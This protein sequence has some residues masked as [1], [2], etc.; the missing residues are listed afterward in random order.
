MSLLLATVAERRVA[1]TPELG[2]LQE[3]MPTSLKGEREP[4]R[5]LRAPPREMRASLIDGESPRNW[6]ELKRDCSTRDA[7]ASTGMTDTLGVA[8][9]GYVEEVRETATE[10][11]E[12]GVETP[13]VDDAV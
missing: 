4:R 12:E 13:C 8:T 11:A 1:P 9:V 6:I 2:A 3:S 10:A 7:T 5:G